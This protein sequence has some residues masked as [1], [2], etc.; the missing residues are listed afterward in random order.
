[1]IDK[2]LLALLGDNKKYI[3]YAVGLMIVGLFANLAITASI[4]YAI[5]YAADYASS[6][7]GAQG[8]I[9]PAVIVII[10]MA[11]RYVTSRMIGDLKD[12]LGRNVKKDLRQKIYDKIIKLGVRTTDNMS[13]A[14]LTQLS[15]E[16]VEQLDLYYSAYIPQFF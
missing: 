2:K 4:C 7:S 13:M 14:G 3:F 16:G 6:G 12:T 11:I 8:F 9:L 1:M 5:Q 10:S 15:M